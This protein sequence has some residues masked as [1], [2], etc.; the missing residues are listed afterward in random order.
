MT[1]FDRPTADPGGTPV[2]AGAPAPGTTPA[3]S[4]DSDTAAVP[5][6]TQ[7][8]APPAKPDKPRQSRARWLAATGLLALIVVATATATL[9]LTSSQTTS[10]VLG[11]VPSGSVAYGELRLDLPGDQRQKVAQFL[12][13]FPGF[14]DQA[15]LDNKLDEVLDRLVGEGSKGKQTFTK[16]IKPWFD[17]QLAFAVGP[18]PAMTGGNAQDAAKDAQGLVLASVKDEALARAWFTSTLQE[19]GVTGT[20]Q[21]YN[22]TE[23]TVFD[24]PDKHPTEAAFALVDGKVAIVG[25]VAS[26]KAAIDTKGKSTV[27]QSE[28]VK[29]AQSAMTGDDLGFMFVDLK[30]LM[31]ATTQAAGASASPLAE[32]FTALVPDWAA[33]RIRVES[34]ALRFDAI[35]PHVDAAPGP[36]SN[37]PN[38][39]AA[40]APPTTVA[41]IAGNDVGATLKDWIELLE[42]EPSLA[43]AYKQVEQIVNVVGGFDG[44]LGWMGD[45]GVVIN[46]AGDSVE[47]G[48][49]SIPTDTA[50]ARQLFTTLRSFLAL[51]GAQAGVT[52]RDETYNGQTITI[53]D[54]GSLRDLAAAAG[55]LGGNA[56]PADPSKLPNDKIQLAYTVTDDVVAIGSSPDFVKHVLDAGAGASLA[57]DARFKGLVDRVGSQHRSLTFLDVAVVRGYIE[58]RMATEASAQEKAEYEESVKPFLTPFDAL[59]SAGAVADG[60]DQTHTQ[61]T[62]K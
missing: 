53:V 32:A 58:T 7:A 12:S 16:D 33:A 6:P 60:L 40:F 50:K 15:A 11:Y 25:D 20:T 29:A 47:G 14:A 51:G 38:G 39:V 35:N 54:L 3:P 24:G 59:I 1:D 5:V 62:V 34:D 27:T 49:V 18:L 42:K 52:V 23:L 30:A 31:T 45:T 56:L 19:A 43:E 13:K 10:T 36:D 8:I 57:D 4:P 28:P 9:V 17:G 44:L 61:I 2:P 41:M 21:S 55:K 37:H 46:P 26:V 22:G 48:I